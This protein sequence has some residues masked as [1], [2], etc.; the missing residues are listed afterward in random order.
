MPTSQPSSHPLEE[1]RTLHRSHDASAVRQLYRLHGG[2]LALAAGVD[3]ERVQ[4]LVERPD[5]DVLR[6]AAKVLDLARHRSRK[7]KR[8]ANFTRAEAASRRLQASV[9]W[10]EE[11]A[12]LDARA[13][14]GDLLAAPSKYICFL[15]EE[16]QIFADKARL[17]RLRGLAR[18]LDGLVVFLTEHALSFRWKGGRGGLDFHTRVSSSTSVSDAF[19]VPLERPKV[20]SERGIRGHILEAAVNLL[21][22]AHP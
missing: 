1:L 12:Y 3:T 7:Q 8:E 11:R 15:H 2:E 17:S 14:L 4:A 9:R 18:R 13:L 21:Q 10:R 6:A 22:L 5:T 19:I 16:R 20:P